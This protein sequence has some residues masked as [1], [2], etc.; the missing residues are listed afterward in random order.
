MK[1]F[2]YLTLIMVTACGV[3][4]TSFDYGKTTAADLIA[5]KGEPEA[6]T[7]TPIKG[8]EIYQYPDNEKFQVK[9]DVVT[10]ALKD[11]KGDEKTVLYWKHKFKDCNTSTKVISEAKDHELAQYELKCASEGITVIFSEGSEFVSRI[12]EHE[13]Q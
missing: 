6:K 1:S 13:K 12:I 2:I 5:E 7:Q 4:R 8:T 3:K 9:D 10:H 11:P